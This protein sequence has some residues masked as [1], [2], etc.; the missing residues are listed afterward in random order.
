MRAVRVQEQAFTP[1][2]VP[3][4]HAMHMSPLQG[5]LSSLRYVPAGQSAG[6]DKC[7]QFGR[8][9]CV[10]LASAVR[11]TATRAGASRATHRAGSTSPSRGRPSCR[12]PRRRRRRCSCTVR[13]GPLPKA[14]IRPQTGRQTSVQ[15]RA[16]AAYGQASTDPRQGAL[17]ARLAGRPAGRPPTDAPSRCAAEQARQAAGRRCQCGAGH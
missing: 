12:R 17:S 13:R 15:C 6:R 8:D 14:D 10:L 1:E 4:G 11:D 9:M 2:Y 7:P 5:F 3:A 16:T